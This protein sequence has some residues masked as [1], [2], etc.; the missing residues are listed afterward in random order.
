MDVPIAK[1]EPRG[2]AAGYW[3]ENWWIDGPVFSTRARGSLITTHKPGAEP[4]RMPA[5]AWVRAA[6]TV[7]LW[8]GAGYLVL[9]R[10]LPGVTTPLTVAMSGSWRFWAVLAIFFLSVAAFGGTFGLYT[11][12]LDRYG[13]AFASTITAG[14]A[15]AL[16]V[17]IAAE[18]HRR[19]LNDYVEMIPL[20]ERHAQQVDMTIMSIVVLV[21][22]AFI[23]FSVLVVPFAVSGAVREQRRIASIRA[24]GAH[25]VGTLGRVGHCH[26]RVAGLCQFDVTVR[27]GDGDGVRDVAAQMATS[28]TRVPLPG[29]KV[30]VIV[31]PPTAADIQ[32]RPARARSRRHA[33]TAP[34]AL[35]IEPDP[36]HV[37]AFDPNVERYAESSGAGGA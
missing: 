2:S 26:Q 6:L 29:T 23:V 31:S 4:G 20:G 27:F 11:R 13:Q 24:T 30:V 18:V 12:L 35:L 36:T 28:P 17:G 9:P 7:L 5:D 10:I 3:P 14:A 16:G 25:H 8:A 15:I 33:T 1:P 37:I 19:L 21:V 22:A 32:P 34:E